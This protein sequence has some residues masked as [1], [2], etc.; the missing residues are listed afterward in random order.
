MGAM[1]VGVGVARGEGDYFAEW[2]GTVNREL[3][4]S[5]RLHQQAALTF[6]RLK[7]QLDDH[8]RRIKSL[9]ASPASLRDTF[10]TY[11]GCISQI[12]GAAFISLNSLIALAALVVSLTHKP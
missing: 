9:E 3:E 8:D 4:E 12:I 5:A 11:G 7:G 1:G 6:E 10:G 2:R